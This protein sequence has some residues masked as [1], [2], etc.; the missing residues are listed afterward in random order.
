MAMNNSTSTTE[1]AQNATNGSAGG[2]AAPVGKGGGGPPDFIGGVADIA[3]GGLDT[4]AQFAGDVLRGIFGCLPWESACA[5]AGQ[6]V[7]DVVVTML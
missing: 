7:V 3:H 4:A 6:I 1:A 2:A 5:P